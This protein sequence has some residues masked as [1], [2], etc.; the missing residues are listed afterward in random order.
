M[1]VLDDL[2]VSI[3]RLMGDPFSLCSFN[4]GVTER[5]TKNFKADGY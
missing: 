2:S 1:F 4:D 3:S 5:V